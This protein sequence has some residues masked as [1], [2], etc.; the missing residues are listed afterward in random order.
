MDFTPSSVRALRTL[1][2]PYGILLVLIGSASYGMLS[3]FVKLAYKTGATTAELT[4]AQFFWGAIVL[5]FLAKF[6]V[7]G[8]M[9]ATRKE[10][11]G[12]LFAGTTIGLTSV[13]YYVSVTYIPASIA[14]VLLMQ[15][16][17]MGVLFECVVKREFP[18]LDKVLAVI[19][20][21]V[22]TVL[23]TGTLSGA[24][25]ASVSN[26]DPIGVIF[27]L[28][29]AVSYSATLAATGSVA[30]HLHPVK[31]SQFMLYGGSMV[32][33]TF[34][35]LSQI[36]PYH[37]GLNLLG[38]EFTRAKAFNFDIL[39]SYGLLLA[40]FGTILPPIVLNRG[41]PITGVALGSIIS[42][43]ELPFAMLIASLL[44]NESITPLQGLGVAVILMSVLIL[45][46]RAVRSTVRG[47]VRDPGRNFETSP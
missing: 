33:V 42:S 7:R 31:R 44:L 47:T 6:T 25:G 13:L 29:S 36:M 5:T 24:Q 22:G 28:L 3:T 39:F 8:S 1:N 45:N 16:I 14:V 32:V 18:T 37:F 34:V 38:E 43:I 20:I 4:G 23:A 35:V 26:L 15:S 11:L 21:L 30:P 9:K 41:F 19:L 17:W 27:G 40:L 10:K 46:L 2:L 12:L